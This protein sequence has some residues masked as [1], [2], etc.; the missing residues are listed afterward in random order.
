MELTRKQRMSIVTTNAAA[1]DITPVDMLMHILNL[2]KAEVD[3][4]SCIPFA[5]EAT[6]NLRKRHEKNLH[7]L[8]SLLATTAADLEWDEQ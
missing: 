6:R 5:N 7:H 4:L 2:Q 8:K 1:L 3:R